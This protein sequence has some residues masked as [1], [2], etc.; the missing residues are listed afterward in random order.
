V[1]HNE[2]ADWIKTEVKGKIDSMNWML[3]K[4]TELVKNSQLEASWKRPKPNYWL[5]VFPA[6]HSNITKF[7]NT[8]IDELKQMSDWLT[9]GITYLLPKSWDTK[10]QK[11]YRPITCLSA[12]YKTLTGKIARRISV[13]LEEHN[14]LPAEQKE[15]HSGSKGCKDQLLI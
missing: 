11:N 15:C 7:S 9:T 10:E 12:M 8:L 1:Q 4:T 3:V 14:L 6:T 5:K 13:H 2:K